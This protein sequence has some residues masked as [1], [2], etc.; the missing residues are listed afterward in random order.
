[1]DAFLLLLSLIVLCPIF[2]WLLSDSSLQS[3]QQNLERV[4]FKPA[5]S[6]YLSYFGT[7]KLPLYRQKPVNNSLLRG[8]TIKGIIL[9][10]K[11]TKIANDGED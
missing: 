4:L 3:V 2:Y 6:R 7:Y 5:Q 11:G 1:M 10:H 9:N 8:K